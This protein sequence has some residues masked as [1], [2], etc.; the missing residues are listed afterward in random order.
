MLGSTW[1]GINKISCSWSL[2]KSDKFQGNLKFLAVVEW[3]ACSL[4]IQR[5]E[6]K[7]RLSLQLLRKIVIENNKNKQNNT[8]ELAHL[9]NLLLKLSN[10]V[11]KVFTLNRSR[12]TY[13]CHKQCDQ[14]F[15][16]K[17]APFFPKFAQ[18]ESTAGIRKMSFLTIAQTK[19]SLNIL[20]IFWK[21][22]SQ[23]I[24][25]SPNL[26]TLAT[27]WTFLQSTKKPVVV[28]E[29]DDCLLTCNCMAVKKIMKQ[30]IGTRTRLRFF[31]AYDRR[32]FISGQYYKQI[33]IVI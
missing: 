18:K 11:A 4:S 25:K 32:T 7:S 30:L 26:V 29:A 12:A 19:M 14:L 17:E 23:N 8:P 31:I 33:T 27:N 21:I 20:A 24:L 2:T 10:L 22:V 6:F 13:H 5:W 28:V 3:S 15:E 9:K 1:S 16:K